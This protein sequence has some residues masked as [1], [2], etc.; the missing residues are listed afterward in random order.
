MFFIQYIKLTFFTL[1]FLHLKTST[2]VPCRGSVR[3]E[4]VSTHLA[5]SNVPAKPVR[6]W[7]GIDVL[8]RTWVFSLL[9]LP[10]CS[11][12]WIV[13]PE[14]NPAVFPHVRVRFSSWAGSVLPDSVWVQ[15]LRA[16]AAHLSHPGDMLLHSGQSLGTQLW[17]MSS[18]G[19]RWVASRLTIMCLDQ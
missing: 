11:R 13:L 3:T 6:C 14:T 17:K 5:A 7:S 8:V 15:G 18:G 12:H 4:I 19:H 9:A 10:E 2:S 16:S 1:C